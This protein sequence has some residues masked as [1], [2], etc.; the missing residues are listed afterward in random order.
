MS[1]DVHEVYAI[2]YGHH[3]RKAAENFIGGDPHDMLQPLDFYVWA[4]VGA[5]G[6]IACWSPSGSMR[7]SAV[8]ARGRCV[9]G[10]SRSGV[11]LRW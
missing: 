3:R 4:I 7:R 8:R 11:T 6:A 9:R 2:R 10:N 1:D 5:A